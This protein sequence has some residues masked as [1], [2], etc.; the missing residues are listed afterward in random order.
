[1]S[2][3]FKGTVFCN[4]IICAKLY[5]NQ[6][7]CSRWITLDRANEIT[8]LLVC[9][10]LQTKRIDDGSQYRRVNHFESVRIAHDCEYKGIALCCRL[11]TERRCGFTFRV[12]PNRDILRCFCYSLFRWCYRQCNTNRQRHYHDWSQ[13]A[14]YF[15]VIYQRVYFI[16][17]EVLYLLIAPK[18]QQS[19]YLSLY[20]MNVEMPASEIWLCVPNLPMFYLIVLR[21]L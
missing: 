3:N 4:S 21:Y 8:A 20:P 18:Y 14:K 13:A 11:Y 2:E 19:T 10:F 12:I 5:W 9:R 7:I 1:M 16:W 6:Q 17:N 15:M